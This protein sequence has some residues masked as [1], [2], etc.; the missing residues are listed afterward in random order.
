METITVTRFYIEDD[1][2]RVELAEFN[3]TTEEHA[4]RLNAVQLPFPDLEDRWFFIASLQN[5]AVDLTTQGSSEVRNLWGEVQM[6][7]TPGKSRP[8]SR[9]YEYEVR[10]GV[11]LVTFDEWREAATVQREQQMKLFPD[12]G[13]PE[14]PSTPPRY[15]WTDGKIIYGNIEVRPQFS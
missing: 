14:I 7:A 15:C 11:T 13:Y 3:E 5:S 12:E 8:A 4:S 9:F 1:Q 10:Q 6:E 2:P